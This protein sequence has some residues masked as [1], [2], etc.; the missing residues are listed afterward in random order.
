[1]IRNY[2]IIPENTDNCWF[3]ITAG[4]F[5]LH[6]RKVMMT[7]CWGM[8]TVIHYNNLKIDDSVKITN[9]DATVTA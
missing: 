1:M 9:S 6:P 2:I 4:K 7:A 8:N 5:E 3:I